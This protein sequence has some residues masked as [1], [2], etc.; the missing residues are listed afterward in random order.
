MLKKTIAVV[1]GLCLAGSSVFARSSRKTGKKTTLNVMY[2]EVTGYT[3]WLEQAKAQFEETHPNVTVKLLCLPSTEAD[4]NTKTALTLQTDNS[5]DVMVTDSFLV[6]SLVGSDCLAPLD[7]SAWADWERQY[8]ESIRSSQT[9][10]GKVHAI[11]YTTDTR[12]LY[13]NA[14][15]FAKAGINMP[16]EPKSWADILD[17][18]KRLQTAGVP[19]PIWMN[20]SKAQGE[21]TSMQ[22]FEMLLSGTNDWL[23]ENGKWVTKSKGFTDSLKF[24]QSLHDMGIYSNMNLATML[25]ANGWQV[26]PEKFAKGSDVGILLDGCWKGADWINALGADKVQDTVKIVPMPRQKGAGFT[27]MSGG[28][29]LAVSKLSSHKDMALN[30][31]KLAVNKENMVFFTTKGGDMTARFDVGSDSRYTQL[32][33]YRTAMTPYIA[34]T[35]FRPAVDGYPSVSIEIQTAVESVISGQKTADEAAA[36]YAANVSKIAGKGNYVEK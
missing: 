26:L 21:G 11:P 28:W 12:G 25:D 22:T 35:R 4:Y 33:Y 20:G 14:K 5:V 23:Y 27:S 24:I 1:V 15:T 17:A 3:P 2:K 10:N 36:V 16:W 29:T 8:P 13:Y 31:I 9:I 34:W 6:A 7:V 30:F 19:Y 32:N 18:V